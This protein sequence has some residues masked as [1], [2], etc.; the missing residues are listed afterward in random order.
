MPSALVLHTLNGIAPR[1]I[2]LTCGAF[3]IQA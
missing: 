3:F 1:R 2:G